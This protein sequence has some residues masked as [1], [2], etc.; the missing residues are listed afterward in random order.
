M[1]RTQLLILAIVAACFAAAALAYP[2]MPE[3]MASHWNAA[4]QADGYMPKLWALLVAPVMSLFMAALFLAIPRIDPLR[5]NIAKFRGAFDSFI[6]VILA[7]MLY[8]QLIMVYWN[9]G[10]RFDFIQLMVPALAALFYCTGALVGRAEMNWFVGIRT[11]WTMSS[12]RVWKKTHALGGKLFKSAGI[13]SLVGLVLPA[14]A[15]AFV[16]A[17][18]IAVAIYLVAYSYLEYRAETRG[19]RKA[20]KNPKRV[21]ARAGRRR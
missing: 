6:A 19:S 9:A 8:L 1:N 7:F 15:I 18:V 21:K 17:P 2:A 12:A 5:K 4:G 13:I 16:T 11:P 3:N 14:Y 10:A 20:G